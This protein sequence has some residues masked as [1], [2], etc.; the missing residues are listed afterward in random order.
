MKLSPTPAKAKLFLA[1]Y[2]LMSI[3]SF[4]QTTIYLE[5][6]DDQLGKGATGSTPNV[7]LSGVDWTID[8][9]GATLSNS[10][11]FRVRNVSGQLVFEARN[12]GTSIWLSPIINISSHTNI[13]FTIDASEGNNNSL[14]NSDT[15]VTEYRIDGGSW[16][17]AVTNGNLSNDYGTVQ[18][19]QTNLSGTTLEIRV[20]ATNNGNNE[21][22]RI[23]NVM[24]TGL[25]PVTYIY[26]NNWSPSD[27]NGVSTIANDINVINGTANFYSNTSCND[28]M[29][30]P[31]GNVTIDNGVTLTVNNEMMLQSSS[32][33]YS[34]LILDGTITGNV[35][36]KRHINIAA[37]SGTTTTE[38]DLVSPPLIGQS[39]GDFRLANPNILSGTIGGNLAFLFGPFNPTTE[40]YIN[41]S[42]SD[43]TN[44]LD[45][46]NGYRTG[47]TD[48]GTYTFTGSIET[49]NVNVTV[50]FG[51]A[52]NWN[53]IGNPYP[54]YLNVQEFLNNVINRTL[55]DINAVGIYGYDGAA[56]DGWTIYNLATTNSSTVITP[57]QGFFIDASANGNMEF[58][59]SMRTTGSS[60]DFIIGRDSNPL[61][62]LKLKVSNDENSFKTNFY[63]ND[64]S[65]L[66]LDPGY[67][68]K[69]WNNIPPSFSIYSHLVE[70]NNGEAMAIQSLHSNDLF[71][72]TIPLGV[73][74][75]NTSE[76]EFSIVESTIPNTI[77]IYLEDIVENTL[78]LL[79]DTTYSLVPT[80]PT[81]GT[82]RFYLRFID[83]QLNLNEVA[84]ESLNIY[85]DYNNKSIVIAGLIQQPTNFQLIDLQGRNIKNIDLQLNSRQNSI[86]T[87]NLTKGIYIAQ[88]RS[89]RG[90][91]IK[92]QKVIIQ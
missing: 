75:P 26:N 82:G 24:V 37:G 92:T 39:F 67:D 87:S 14:D 15:L 44:T 47:S 41:Y 1:L 3:Y 38:N 91:S 81:N 69:I 19:S 89:F 85:T 76:I 55:M 74:T 64:D 22:Q 49:G 23:D 51:G 42:A 13:A 8:F 50:T 46:G 10:Y 59:P 54:S 71:N 52:S 73:N 61:T 30:N 70:N 25:S 45:A 72:V 11:R 78:T 40:T 36:Y 77:N 63:F 7:D 21:Q 20:I 60:D 5:N 35:S 57:G 86:D 12:I 33:Q 34:S 4:G 80:A 68:A 43:D 27:P 83:S 28:F 18:I 31:E 66:S 6:F 53:L 58:T 84:L 32:T 65:S 48:N 17:N 16:T 79:T 2:F 62:Y 88:L 29:T 9:S 90:T 56:E